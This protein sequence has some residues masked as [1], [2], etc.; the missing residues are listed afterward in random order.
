LHHLQPRL[1]L[2]AT[3]GQLKFR[4][5]LFAISAMLACMNTAVAEPNPQPPCG[6]AQPVPQYAQPGRTPNFHVWSECNPSEQWMPPA[7][8]GWVSKDGILVAIAGSFHYSGNVEGLLSRFGAISTLTGLRYWSVTENGWRTL[9]TKA[10]ALDGPDPTQPRGN[11]TVTEMTGGADLYFTETDNRT[12]Q[13]VVYRMHVTATPTNF[14]VAIENVTPV[15]R[16][17]LTLAGPGDLQSMHFLA[18]TARGI[19]SYYG[20]ART[21]VPIG[22]I[23]GVSEASFVNRALALYSHFADIPVEPDRH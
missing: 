11:F 3:M 23:V 10:T 2:L 7:C 20:L 12:A 4:A 21:A 18:R 8:T 1:M 14:V 17:L 19:W 9:I 15:R 6:E 13:P 22:A 16:F 5:G